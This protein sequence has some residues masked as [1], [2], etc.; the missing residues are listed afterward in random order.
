MAKFGV[1]LLAGLLALGCCL[2]G[3]AGAADFPSKPV[4][5]IV[6]Y[7][8]GGGTDMNARALA[9]AATEYLNNQPLIIVN[10]PGA[11]GLLGPK[12]VSTSKPDGYT[13]AMGWGNSEFTFGQYLM[14]IPFDWKK[15]K[16]V[17]AVNALTSCLAVPADSPFKTAQELIDYAKKNPGKL[18]WTH[19][20]RGSFNHAN[21]L[22]LMRVTGI[23]MTEVPNVGGAKT[24]N[25]VAGGHVDCAFF[26][27]F[28]ALSVPDKVRVLGMA[29]PERDPA[30]PNVPTFKEMGVKLMDAHGLFGIGAPAG[31]PDDRVQKLY[32]AFKK[33]ME[34]KA[35]ARIA[36]SLGFVPLGWGPEKFAQAIEQDSKNYGELA[37]KLTGK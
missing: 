30:F 18:K 31:T 24:R 37:K 5:L 20:G 32:E 15:F 3:V 1:V 11:Q 33:T 9:S 12:F 29:Y 35:F 21:G 19:T 23:K 4:Y 14:K 13:L 2:S 10:K 8:P 16:P 28:L 22:D 17:I 7:N 36:S 34:H 6:G 26:A 25:L 27:S